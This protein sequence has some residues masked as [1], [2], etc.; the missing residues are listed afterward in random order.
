M[1]MFNLEPK[2]RVL[3]TCFLPLNK[4]L[5]DTLQ[6]FAKEL[7]LQGASLVVASHDIERVRNSKN[8]GFDLLLLPQ[9]LADYDATTYPIENIVADPFNA[10]LAEV[11]AN[12]GNGVNFSNSRRSLEGLP[13]CTH[14]AR[15]V[16]TSLR[17]SIV[18]AW[19]SGV[20]PVSR[21]WQDVARQMGIPAFCLERGLLPGTWMIDG[22]GLNA[23]SDMRSHPMIRRTL[24]QHSTT[25][26]VVAYRKWY[27]TTQPRKYGSVG[28]GAQALRAK[29]EITGRM[30][31]IFGGLD[32]AGLQPR[33]IAGAEINSPGFA[34][35]RELILAVD[36]ALENEPDLAILFKAHPGEIHN[37]P[38]GFIGRVQV[39]VDVDV[40]DLIHTADVIVAGLTSLSF[41]T[42]L[43]KRPLVLV[44]N[45]PLQGTGTAFEALTS[46]KLPNAIHGALLGSTEVMQQKIDF[47][48]DSLLSHCLYATEDN[49]PG[50]PLS[51][52]AI[53]CAKLG[54]NG[55]SNLEQAA[56]ALKT[57]APRLSQPA[58]DFAQLFFD[59]GAGFNETQSIKKKINRVDTRL[60]FE[61]PTDSTSIQGL[62]FD[63]INE[64]ALIKFKAVWLVDSHGENTPLKSHP[65]NASHQEGSITYFDHND[66]QLIIQLPDAPSEGIINVSFEFELIALGRAA[67]ILCNDKIK[68]SYSGISKM[69]ENLTYIVSERDGQISNLNQAVSERDGQISNL[70]QAV[71][72]RDGQISNLN[73]AVSERDGQIS[74]LNQAVSE[75]DGQISNL[76]QAVSERDGQ[77][78]NLNQ[79]VS[80]RDGQITNL[81]QAVHDKDVHIRNLDQTV[82]D[83]DVHI[84]NLNQIALDRLSIVQE[85]KAS[86]SWRITAP[87]RS[88]ATFFVQKKQRVQLVNSLLPSYI[89]SCGGVLPAIIK[90]AK[91]LKREGW[92]GLASRILILKAQS[93][94]LIEN[95][96]HARTS[97]ENYIATMEPKVE[98]F[99]AMVK[100]A[101]NFKFQPKFS[102]VVPVYNV[103]AQW[104]SAFI[105][106]VLNQ[107]YPNWEL[108]IADD[109]STSPHVKPLLDSFA[110]K[111][112]RIKL[113]FRETNGHI[114]AATNSALKLATGD[115]VCLMDNDDEIAPHALFE[116]ASLLNRDKS[117]DMIYSDEDK[118]DMAGN[119]Y[120]PFFKPDWSPE[121]LE[122]CMYTAHFACYRMSLVRELGGFRGDFNGAQDYDF[123]LRFTERAT[124]I[125]H[126]P[127]VLYHW[128]AIPGSTAASMDAK[129]YVLDAAIRALT[130]RADRVAGGGEAKLGSYSGS[131]DLRYKIPNSPLVS[132]IIPSAG[133]MANV[134]GKDVDLLSQVISSIYEKTTYRNFEIIVVDNN[135]LR[136]DTIAAI[137]PYN[138]QF[139]HFEGKFNIATKMNMGAKV[140]RGEYLLFMNDDIEVITPDWMECML[141]LCQR[142]GVGVV[143]AKLH[144]ENET[145][146]HVGVAFW[147]GLPDHIHR[148]YP[149]TYPGHLFSAVANRNYLAVTGAVLMTKNEIFKSVG[150]FE[151]GFAI[152]YNDIDYCLK[153]FTE[154]YRIVLAAG[155]QLCHYES[156]SREAVVAS[157]EID[158]FQQKWKDVVSYDPYYSSFF[159]N[160][161]PMF[162]LR[163][164]WSATPIFDPLKSPVLSHY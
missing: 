99:K 72:E 52:L 21:V 136:A 62:R 152:N 49:V 6:H 69:I 34:D 155:A 119:R 42:L 61:L 129:D 143:G 58:Q 109:H 76:N 104:L 28:E 146:Q 120:E 13:H 36:H 96:Q 81:N 149:G 14:V 29:L 148:A 11:D 2:P 4:Q 18:L 75:R 43:N 87:V 64:P 67:E 68:K 47:F 73:Q 131:F 63:P 86:T 124:K 46:D 70:N 139:L 91:V 88:I 8:L 80:E 26:V 141:Q 22:G 117:L 121:A 107:V 82:L 108:C 32:C 56:L 1:N 44:A 77:I 114:S 55:T 162:T 159:D 145:L 137:K 53:H 66:P 20:Y 150:G 59:T 24:M 85:I 9:S 40:I 7:R 23:Q 30:V 134:R 112:K 51:E 138:C 130:E 144:F 65:S 128:R 45:S 48:L 90:V 133:R 25:E 122:G 102:I 38:Q 132:I 41:E 79:A 163:H 127:K 94:G 157:D 151:E 140:A 57:V 10:W 153:V 101:R 125:A 16:M 100:L 74:N 98:D 35:S 103:E 95:S 84:R 39:V 126:I 135:D 3:M 97:Y 110:A 83:K 160:H 111:D 33:T 12:W 31:V 154:G 37:F 113:I 92:N 71:S 156:V 106:S 147:N 5:V 105:E 164:E 118:L 50:L 78:S 17:P 15:Q 27:Q 115:F 93:E 142:K 89:D 54:A 19:S 158:L 161:P 123:V 60:T 116:F